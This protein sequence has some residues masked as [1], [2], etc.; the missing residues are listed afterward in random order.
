MPPRRAVPDRGHLRTIGLTAVAALV[1]AVHLGLGG[2]LLARSRW[3]GWAAAI[4]LL[5]VLVKLFAL[6][7]VAVHRGKATK[8]PPHP[9]D[10]S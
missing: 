4:V 7:Y 6:G 1:I 2:A 5:L 9:H 10:Q 8:A 3:M